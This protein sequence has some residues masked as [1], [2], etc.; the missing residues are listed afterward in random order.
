MKFASWR[1]KLGKKKWEKERE[2]ENEKI[3][4]KKVFDFLLFWT[5]E[6]AV[7]AEARNGAKIFIYCDS[8]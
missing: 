7:A 8:R 6:A 2:T 5:D 1:Q 3:D 4:S